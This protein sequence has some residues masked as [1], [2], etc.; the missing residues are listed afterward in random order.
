M[1]YDEGYEVPI[2]HVWWLDNYD[3]DESVF[4]NMP[5]SGMDMLSTFKVWNIHSRI[6]IYHIHNMQHV[7]SIFNISITYQ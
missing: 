1:T 3:W 4:Y 5:S 6:S 2:K 7:D